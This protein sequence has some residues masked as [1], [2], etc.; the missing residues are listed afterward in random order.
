MA[1]DFFCPANVCGAEKIA[2]KNPFISAEFNRILKHMESNWVQSMYH[3]SCIIDWLDLLISF[4]DA[5][6]EA[7][8]VEDAATEPAFFSFDFLSFLLQGKKDILKISLCW[9]T[10]LEIW[11]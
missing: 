7:N 5:G 9:D 3:L 2:V 6:I 1:I 11:T 8:G 10:A 4:E